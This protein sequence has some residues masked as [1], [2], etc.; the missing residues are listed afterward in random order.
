MVMTNK[1]PR[2]PLPGLPPWTATLQFLTPLGDN[3]DSP[4]LPKPGNFPQTPLF[5]SPS[6]MLSGART[7]CGPLWLT[8]PVSVRTRVCHIICQGARRHFLHIGRDNN[9]APHHP[10]VF[11]PP[12]ELCDTSRCSL[13]LDLRHML[14]DSRIAAKG[15]LQSPFS[16]ALFCFTL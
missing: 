14:A 3:R 13:S 9:S 8:A 1:G 6:L 10:T 7:H 12:P 15:P 4:G 5:A 2:S 11:Q 16:A